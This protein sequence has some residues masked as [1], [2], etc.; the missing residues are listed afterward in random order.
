M[1]KSKTLFP[2]F[3]TSV[4]TSFVGSFIMLIIKRLVF[5]LLCISN[6]NYFYITYLVTKNQQSVTFT[7][8]V[9]TN[10]AKNTHETFS[11]QIIKKNNNK[12]VHS[13]GSYDFKYRHTDEVKLIISE[14]KT[15]S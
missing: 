7:H 1:L 9:T 4:S 11:F 15:F 3:L 5:R 10:V 14:G 2:F 13:F 6:K 12:S 8:Y